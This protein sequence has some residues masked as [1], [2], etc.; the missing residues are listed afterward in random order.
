MANQLANKDYLSTLISH[1]LNLKGPSLTINTACS[2]SLVTIHLAV[3]ALL[4]GECEILL[5]RE[6]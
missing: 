2:T 1:R 5:L 3:Q 6:V 4:N